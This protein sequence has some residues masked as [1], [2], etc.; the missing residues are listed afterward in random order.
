MSDRFRIGPSA[1]LREKVRKKS[2]PP[3]TLMRLFRW[4]AAD[5]HGGRA[6]RLALS[7]ADMEGACG[8]G[9]KNGG[10]T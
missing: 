3:A 8:T 4:R 2:E 6:D 9:R 7:G 10:Y 5:F 1:I